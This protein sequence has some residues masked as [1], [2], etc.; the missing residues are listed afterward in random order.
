MMAKKGIDARPTELKEEQM[1]HESTNYAA[2]PEKMLRDVHRMN[3]NTLQQ[4][5]TLNSEQKQEVNQMIALL[6]SQQSSDPQ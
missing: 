4:Y 5:Q 2:E 1:D 6:L 3:P